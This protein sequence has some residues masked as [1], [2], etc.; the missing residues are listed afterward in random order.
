M[1][2]FVVRVPV[3]TAVGVWSYIPRTLT[4][5]SDPSSLLPLLAAGALP[6][7][8]RGDS[9]AVSLTGLGDLSVRTKL[10][11][12]VKSARDIPRA[13]DSSAVFQLEE[14]GGLIYIGGATPSGGQ[15][16]TL[17]VDDAAAGDISLTLNALA[18]AIL[19]PGAC[20]YDVQM[21]SAEGV[22][23]LVQGSAAVTADVTRAIS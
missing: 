14:S 3:L 6:P 19:I 8:R 2:R 23:S 15:D 22:T 20:I 1:E 13:G 9:W 17:T 16:G 10:W 4:T 21:L 12:T 7:V 11:I 5:P 18:T